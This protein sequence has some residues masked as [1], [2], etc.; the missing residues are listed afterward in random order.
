LPRSLPESVEVAIMGMPMNFDAQAA[1][2]VASTIQFRVSGPDAGS[3]TLRVV[4]GSCE[5]SEGTADAPDLTIDTPGV[6]WLGIARG[7][8]DPAQA[9]VEQRYSIEGDSTILLRLGD[10]FPSGR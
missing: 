1:A 7:E 10:W 2:G 5:S 8:L 9:L 4:D 3:Y 6:V